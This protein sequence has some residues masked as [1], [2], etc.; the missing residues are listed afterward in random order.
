MRFPD[1]KQIAYD[2]E[3][4]R[5]KLPK[6]GWVRLRLSRPIEGE[7][8]NVSVSREGERWYAS[9]QT[10]SADIVPSSD[11]K[12]TLGLDLGVNVF[13]A[14][15]DGRMIEPLNAYKLHQCRL[16]RYQRA[17]SRKVKGSEN[18]KKAIVRLGNMHRKIARMRAD[19][20][21]QLT[22]SLVHDHPVIALEDLKISNMSRSARG[23]I[24][25]PGKN[26][27]QKAGLNRSI[28]D[29]SWGEAA[30]Q[31]EYKTAAVGGA[32]VYVN[33]SYSS[34]ECRICGHVEKANRKTQESFVCR[35]CGHAEN[36]DTNASKIVL[37]RGCDDWN[38]MKLS[39]AG[40]AATVHGEI[41]RPS[42]VAKPKKAVSAKW[43]PTE[44][45]AYV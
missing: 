33:P 6:V 20:L 24:E 1:S 9:I 36:A 16:R 25:A 15:S 19:W 38:E 39:A 43:K 44:E 4:E 41:V 2:Q 27:R 45:A 5:I 23:T 17:V 8:R 30:R 18:R 21:H 31:L 32:V 10:L 42:K 40:H 22:S 13:A 35:A 11:L 26:V 7:I 12:P 37:Q 14:G 29:Q 28:L 3:N 34:Q